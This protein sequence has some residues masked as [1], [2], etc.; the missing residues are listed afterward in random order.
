M[1]RLQR[2][3][4]LRVTLATLFVGGFLLT[5]FLTCLSPWRLPAV[6]FWSQL[7]ATVSAVIYIVAQ[8]WPWQELAG[9]VRGD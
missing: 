8:A 1:A 4:G 7:I 5:L 2:S 6:A 9:R 3:R